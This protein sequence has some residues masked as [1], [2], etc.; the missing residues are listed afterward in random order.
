[1]KRIIKEYWLII[2]SIAFLIIFFLISYVTDISLNGTLLAVICI[3]L[4]IIPI[5]IFAWKKSAKFKKKYVLTFIITRII[6][7][8]I[9]FVI[10]LV[11]ILSLVNPYNLSSIPN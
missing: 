3:D 10:T 7:I 8:I 5:I 11:T 6:V 9:L 1:M 4:V 2:L